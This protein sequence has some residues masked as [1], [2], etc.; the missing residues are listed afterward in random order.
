MIAIS[1]SVCSCAW[2]GTC[3]PGSYCDPAQQD[4][5]AADG[6]QAH[7][8][9]ELERLDAVPG[10]EAAS[11]RH[12][13]PSS[14]SPPLALT[15]RD[16]D[17]LVVDDPLALA[18][19]LRSGP[20]GRAAR[21]PAWPASPSP[22]RRRRRGSPRRSPAAAR[23]WPSRRSP[24]RRTARPMDGFSRIDVLELGEVLERGRQVGAELLAAVLDRRV[25]R[26]GVLE[27]PEPEAHHRAA[28]DLALDERRVDRPADVVD[29][30][31]ASAPSISPVSSST[32]TSTTHA[33]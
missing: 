29:L 4:L 17:L 1:C 23:C 16:R 26:V 22:R 10:A 18:A 27:Q 24:W 25:V 7:A 8:V 6:V 9:D 2:R 14:A 28:L 20:P 30:E 31:H 15:R 19:R 12:G 21:A 5:V 13:R 11:L 32:S 3:L 33:A